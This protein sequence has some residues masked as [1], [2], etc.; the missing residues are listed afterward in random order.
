MA[1]MDPGALV[2]GRFEVEELA[3]EGGMG[4]V[5]RCLDRLSGQRVALKVQ[6]GAPG[7]LKR[8]EREA[9]LL[10]ELRHPSVVRYVAHGLLD[11][12]QLYL[13]MEWLDGE[14][15]EARLARGPLSIG[16]AQRLAARLAE[17]LQ[18]IH[19]RGI[20]HRDLKPSNLFLPRGALEEV[21]LLDFGVAGLRRAGPP[22]PP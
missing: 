9:Q 16:D 10:A 8:F 3:A 19:A 18:A 5:Y 20:V 6:P 11:G 13:A 15:L 4:S 17:V 21:K 22:P 7:D 12:G 1:A 14:S 2:S